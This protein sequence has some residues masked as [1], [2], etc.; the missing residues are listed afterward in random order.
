MR[1]GLWGRGLSVLARIWDEKGVVGQGV[2]CASKG[3][4]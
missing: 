3:L 2:E 1:R 4:G